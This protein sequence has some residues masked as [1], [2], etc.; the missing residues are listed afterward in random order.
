MNP[1]QTAD[2]LLGRMVERSMAAHHRLRLRR[3]GRLDA[4]EPPDDGLPWCRAAPPPRP[5]C[6]IEILIDGAEVLPGCRRRDPRRPPLR[7]HRRLARGAALRR[8]TWRAADGAARTAHRDGHPRRRR[9]RAALGG[10]PLRVSSP[11]R[12]PTCARTRGSSGRG[13]ASASR[14]TR[15]S[16][17]CTATTRSSSSLTM[18]LPLSAGSTS[19]TWAETGGTPGRHPARGRLGWHDA[20]SRLRGPVVADVVE[21][22][23]LRWGRGDR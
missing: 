15:T 20:G 23:D 13:R 11:R 22:F 21:H 1:I 10:A 16:A 8:R 17:S 2:L 12:A 4:L 5:G 3:V 14:W 9:A 18:R 7:P 6:S 19:P